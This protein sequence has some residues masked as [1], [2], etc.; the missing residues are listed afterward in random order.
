MSV[1]FRQMCL[2]MEEVAAHPAAVFIGQAVARE[3]TAMSRTLAGVPD[4]KK[5]ELPVAEEMQMGLALGLAL[6]GDLPVAIYPRWNFLLLA[7]GQL[8]L[9]VDKLP[10]YSGWR[11]RPRVI[12]RTAVA[13]PDPLDPGPQ[14][15]GDYTDP[16]A[17]ML[18]T[19]TVVKLDDARS[20]VPAYRDA[21]V[22]EGSTL[23]V[24]HL[25]RY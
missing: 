25:G 7:M 21:V 8:V 17:A 24:E 20:I 11:C 16:V 4:D 14:H 5:V 19:V 10:V 18:R 2:A 12:V 13:S 22:R 3:G 1:Y 23:L 9:H 6:A 15:L